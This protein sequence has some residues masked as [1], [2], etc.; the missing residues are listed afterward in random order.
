MAWRIAGPD[1]SVEG[2]A[3]SKVPW[4]KRPEYKNR[5]RRKKAS[6]RTKRK[7][8]TGQPVTFWRE[9][10]ALRR[11]FIEALGDEEKNEGPR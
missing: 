1:F 10:Y 5:K 6:P 8:A 4:W 3:V 11:Q 9:A 7:A 2:G